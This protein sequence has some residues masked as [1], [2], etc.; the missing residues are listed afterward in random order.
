MRCRF[1]CRRKIN[2]CAFNPC[3]IN[4]RCV[5]FVN[6]YRCECNDGYLV[7]VSRHRAHRQACPT[8]ALRNTRA[9]AQRDTQVKHARFQRTCVETAHVRQILTAFRKQSICHAASASDTS[10]ALRERTLSHCL[11]LET[12]ALSTR[13]FEIN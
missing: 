1:D 5:D 6:E 12:R 2:K 10:S 9:S 8:M 3:G 11:S 7:T 4:G 13:T